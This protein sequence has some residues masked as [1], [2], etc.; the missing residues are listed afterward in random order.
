MNSKKLNRAFLITIIL[1]IGVMFGVPFLPS[2]WKE[3]LIFNNLLCESVIVLPGLLFLLFSKENVGSFLH[4]KKIKP[5]T[6][7]AIVP[8]T[9]F[10][11]PVI[12]LANILSQLFAKNEA[13]AAM[14]NAKVAEMPFLLLLFSSGIFAPFCEELVCR[15]IYYRGYKKSGSGFKAMLLSAVLFALFHMNL[16][17]AAYA[18][19]M[20]LLAVLLV[21]A[22]G[23]LWSSIF[24]HMLINSSQ[25]AMTY[26]MLKANASAYSEASEL[27]NMEMI[28]MMVAAYLVIT[29]VT[30]PLAW[31]LLVWM[32]GHEERQGALM[33]LW[34]ERKKKEDK[35]VTVPLI[36]AIILC[37][38]II[39]GNYVVQIIYV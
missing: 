1:Y 11:I 20:G 10:S 16:N 30:L 34:K 4:F 14:E 21:E 27:I 8:F 22:T 3:N 2:A 35:L 15:G 5:G 7:L 29:A 18:F 32:S 39:I 23:S 9:M 31:A 19:V 12:T 24:Y 26:A 25:V 6:L 17:Q 33:L 38:V 36:L 13:V 28:V 37:M